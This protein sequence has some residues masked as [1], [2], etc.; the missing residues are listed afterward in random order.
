MNK[1]G[2][3]LIETIMVIAIIAILSMILVPNVI[4]IINKNKEKSCKNLISSIESATEIYVSNHRY[5]LGLDCNEGDP[6]TYIS[7]KE[8]ID[9]G[10]LTEPVKNPIND[11]V[12]NLDLTTVEVTFNCNN[13]S[14]SY[15]FK[16]V[17]YTDGESK[18]IEC[19]LE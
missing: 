12:I 17:V 7:L 5:D 11:K 14:F 4:V 8:L 6:T 15:K 10:D 18:E 13:K 2:F 19:T 3:T 1:K 9:S 16:D